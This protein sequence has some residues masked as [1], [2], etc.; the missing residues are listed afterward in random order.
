VVV[1]MNCQAA[2]KT[3]QYLGW[4]V[5]QATIKDL[6]QSEYRNVDIVFCSERA[7]SAVAGSAGR[8]GEPMILS[9]CKSNVVTPAGY[10]RLNIAACNY[11]GECGREVCVVSTRPLFLNIDVSRCCHVSTGT[12]V[13][14][15]LPPAF[16]LMIFIWLQGSWV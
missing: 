3:L 13:N 15:E 8:N 1:G 12:N 6:Q 16:W 5:Q 14:A 10:Y 2:T 11:G 9:V 4:S 7:L